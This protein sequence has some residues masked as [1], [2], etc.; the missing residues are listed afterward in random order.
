MHNNKWASC[1]LAAVSWVCENQ[2]VQPRAF[3]K[4][5]YNPGQGEQ[6][7][8]LKDCMIRVYLGYRN[9]EIIEEKNRLIGLYFVD[10]QAWSVE[11]GIWA[12]K[13]YPW[14]IDIQKVYAARIQTQIQCSFKSDDGKYTENSQK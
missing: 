1:A 2:G 12:L 9:I 5:F 14:Y 7:G 13:V 4:V 6:N 11:Q 8:L 10:T 3:T